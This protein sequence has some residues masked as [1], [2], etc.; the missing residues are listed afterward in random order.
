MK[1]QQLEEEEHEPLDIL[2]MLRDALQEALKAVEQDEAKP[3]P[4]TKAAA[5]R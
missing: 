2:A 4:L 1:E 3:E 5:G